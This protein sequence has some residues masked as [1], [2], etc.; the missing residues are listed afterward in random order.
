[1]RLE[2]DMSYEMVAHPTMLKGPWGNGTYN[3]LRF[4][5]Y[6]VDGRLIWASA[7]HGHQSRSSPSS[8]LPSAARVPMLLGS[9][10]I[11]EAT[12]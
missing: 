10:S 1:M 7:I 6:Y 5:T 8:L 11:V 9:P 2:A 3:R 4:G 12:R